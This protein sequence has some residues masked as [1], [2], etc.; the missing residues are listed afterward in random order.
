[1]SVDSCILKWN[2][3]LSLYF[4]IYPLLSQSLRL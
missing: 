4:V 3:H 2:N 1:M